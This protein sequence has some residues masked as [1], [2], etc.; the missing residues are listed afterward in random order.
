[1]LTDESGAA[2]QGKLNKLFAPALYETAALFSFF[3]HD[4]WAK[5]FTELNPY[6]KIPPSSKISGTILN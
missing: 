6:W 5:L 4:T 2:Q 3:D 1:M